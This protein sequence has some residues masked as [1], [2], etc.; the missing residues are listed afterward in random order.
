MRVEK[1]QTEKSNNNKS[2]KKGEGEKK[3]QK[4][5]IKMKIN[6]FNNKLKS[7]LLLPTR[8]TLTKFFAHNLV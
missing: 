1:R 6:K 4:I 3:I 2:F 8:H 7:L 5:F